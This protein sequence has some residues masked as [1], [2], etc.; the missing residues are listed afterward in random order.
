MKTYFSAV[1]DPQGTLLTSTAGTPLPDQAQQN[2]E[3]LQQM[4]APGSRV[5]QVEVDEGGN[6]KSVRNEVKP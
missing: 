3:Y 6:S 4:A 2:F 5:V 1:L